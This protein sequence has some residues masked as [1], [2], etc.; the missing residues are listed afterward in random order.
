M[1]GTGTRGRYR[2]P[3]WAAGRGTVTGEVERDVWTEHEN[4][5]P[6]QDYSTRETVRGVSEKGVLVCPSHTYL[7]KDRRGVIPSSSA[8]VT[9]RGTGAHRVG[10]RTDDPGAGHPRGGK[11]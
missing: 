3:W 1:V 7:V 4:P 8:D 10:R 2:D 9:V 6:S 5:G 11:K